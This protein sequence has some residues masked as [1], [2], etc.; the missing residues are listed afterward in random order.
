MANLYQLF[1]FLKLGMRRNNSKED[2]FKSQNYQAKLII[3]EIRKR[4]IT[5]KNMKMLELGCGV[6]GYSPQFKKEV[7]ELV[8]ADMEEPDILLKKYPIKFLKFDVCK[9]FPIR[10]KEFDFVF[11]SN[12]IEHVCNPSLMLTEINRVLRDDGILILAFPPFYSPL[13][14]HI[15]APFHYFGEKFSIRLTNFFKRKNIK[16]YKTAYGAWGLYPLKTSDV[17]KLLEK[18]GFNIKDKWARYFP[19]NIAKIPIINDIVI[20]QVVF[21]CDKVKL[22]QR[23]SK[24]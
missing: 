2:Y 14:G 13:G 1:K 8:V 6:G 11:C 10:T 21:L 4:G 24:K 16:S 19:L 20:W 3:P 17:E 22:K 9:K 5:L 15:F 12:V 18:A 23:T 7:R